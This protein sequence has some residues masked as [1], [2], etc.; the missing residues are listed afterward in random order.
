MDKEKLIKQIMAEYEADGEPITREEA[1]EIAEM[2]IKAKGLKNY[3][4]TKT[5]KEKKPRERKVDSEKAFILGFV[6]LGLGNL[7]DKD[8][9]ITE[10]EVKLH[11][12]YNDCDY[13][14]TLTKHR[15][16]K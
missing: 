3:T 10:N 1:E 14:I 16:K 4:Q 9:I 5:T 13:S 12:N 6:K 11:F 2:E 7:V 8:N 15:P